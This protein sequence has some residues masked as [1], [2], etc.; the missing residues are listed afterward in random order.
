MQREGSHRFRAFI[1]YSHADKRWGIWLHGA[2]EGYRIPRA[3]GTGDRSLRPV[4]R[5][6]AELAAS[7]DLGAAITDALSRSDAMIVI[8]SP[9][10]AQSHWV[11]KEIRQFQALGRGERIFG[12]IVDGIPHDTWANCFPPAFDLP[13]E[14]EANSAEPLAIDLR[15]HGRHDSL[16]KILAGLLKVDYD[17]LKRRDRQRSIRRIVATTVAVVAVFA[18]YSLSLFFQARSVNL[19]ASSVLAALARGASE[20]GDPGRALRFGVLSASQ[21]MISPIAPEAEPTLI[22][23]YYSSPLRAEFRDHHFSVYSVAFDAASQQLLSASQD[24]TVRIYSRGTEGWK[25]D[26][27]AIETGEQLLAARFVGD[28]AGV[29][30]LPSSGNAISFWQQNAGVWKRSHPF[31][32]ETDTIR[33]FETSTDGTLAVIGYADGSAEIWRHVAEGWVWHQ[34][35]PAVAQV[36]TAIAVSRDSLQIA[37]GYIDGSVGLFEREPGGRFHASDQSSFFSYEVRRLAFSAWGNR[38]LGTAIGE[39]RLASLD[40]DGKWTPGVLIGSGKGI[41]NGVFLT[42]AGNMF[43]ADTG[44]SA[45]TLWTEAPN[46]TWVETATFGSSM[47]QARSFAA[48]PDGRLFATGGNDDAAVRIWGPGGAENWTSFLKINFGVGLV[49]DVADFTYSHTDFRLETVTSANGKRSAQGNVYG[50]VTVHDLASGLELASFDASQT[51]QYGI[52]L[53]EGDTVLSVLDGE[54]TPTGL[55]IPVALA[56]TLTGA[57]LISRICKDRLGGA[58][59]ILDAEDIRAAPILAGRNSEDVCRPVSAWDRITESLRFLFAG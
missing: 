18:I 22:R 27:S 39:L 57:E 43:L 38:L 26:A 11:D 9:R 8:C 23:A 5:D 50:V 3:L 36:P 35:L 40:P 10:S 2:L 32:R 24:E 58:L 52:A 47:Q 55:D 13:G 16:L 20:A 4:F 54:G 28:G 34:A 15:A 56:F 30:T 44:D 53:V 59:S 42:E 1:S 49:N 46:G 17:R 19:Q 31:G 12:L 21:T 48:A 6:D 37:I 45:V 29:L 14:G 25:E 7:A 51:P 41:S 33:A